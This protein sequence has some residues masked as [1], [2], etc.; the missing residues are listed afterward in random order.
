LDAAVQNEK[1]ES[2]SSVTVV[3]VPDAARR[4]RFELYRTANTDASGRV[5]FENVV[6]GDYKVFAWEVVEGGAWQDPDFLRIHEERGKPVRVSEGGREL[7]DV[8]MIPY[9]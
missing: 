6:P 5:H 8:R 9:R 2:V 3:L 1:Q 4:Q 7:V